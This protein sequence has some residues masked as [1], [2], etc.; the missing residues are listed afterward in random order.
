LQKRYQILVE[1]HMSTCQSSAPGLR[2]RLTKSSS[3]A[4]AEG[5]AR[6]YNNERVSLPALAVPLLERAHTAVAQQCDRYA[7]CLQDVSPLPYTQHPSKTDRRVMYSRDDL[8]YELQTALL[9]SD[10]DGAPLAPVCL[11]LAAAAG[12]HT[13]R[14]EGLLPTRPWV[15][16]RNRTLG[17]VAAQQ[18]AKL[19]V[20]FSD[21]AG[22]KLLQLRR[23]QRCDRLFVIRANDVRRVQHAGQSCLLAAVEATC[24]D[25]FTFSRTVQYKG[26]KAYQYVA[27]TAVVLDQPARTYRRRKGRLVQRNL[28]GRPLSLRLILAQVRDKQGRVL[29][30]WRL[31]S[32]LGP[33][34]DAATIALW[35]YWRSP[36][37]VVLQAAQARRPAG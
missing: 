26:K 22:D 4:A 16:E 2:V 35:Y 6:F 29:A 14:R 36:R 18:F 17:Y 8:G 31:W 21:R 5:A 23:F 12:V 25:Q 28:P 30:T 34:V 37:R 3:K 13:T 33:D 32:N 27:E 24:A 11:N 19:L 9:V 20:H 1:Q 15:D 7:L 10:L